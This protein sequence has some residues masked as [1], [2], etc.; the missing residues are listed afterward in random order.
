MEMNDMYAVSDLI[1][2]KLR[3]LQDEGMTGN[4]ERLLLR[5]YAEQLK[6]L[7]NAGLIQ[8]YANEV[9]GGILQTVVFKV[10]HE[11]SKKEP[12]INKLLNTLEPVDKFMR[13]KIGLDQEEIQKRIEAPDFTIVED[14]KTLEKEIASWVKEMPH[15]AMASEVPDDIKNGLNELKEQFMKM[16]KES[17]KWSK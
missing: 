11:L 7:Q 6:D 2:Q 8:S 12:D 13:Q 15:V 17:N 3:T 4:I 14:L 9:F 16:K 10:M 5:P 1:L